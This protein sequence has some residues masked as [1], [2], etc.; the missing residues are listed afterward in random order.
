MK[1]IEKN[2]MNICMFV[3]AK[4]QIVFMSDP[5]CQINNFLILEYRV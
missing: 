3:K 5:G 4:E 1:Y 2:K